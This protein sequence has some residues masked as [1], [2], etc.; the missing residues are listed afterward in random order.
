M[1]SNIYYTIF[2]TFFQE[3]HIKKSHFFLYFKEFYHV[4]NKYTSILYYIIKAYNKLKRMWIITWIFKLYMIKYFCETKHIKKLEERK[5][6][7][8]GRF[9]LP[10]TWKGLRDVGTWQT[11][12]IWFHINR[13]KRA[14]ILG[15]LFLK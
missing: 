7:W 13:E 4:F 3:I 10:H 8:G 9:C 11:Y 1:L 6:I 2:V 5:H 14:L 12:Q 15:V